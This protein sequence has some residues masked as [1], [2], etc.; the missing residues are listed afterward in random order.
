MAAR[1]RQDIAADPTRGVP[2]KGVALQA[3]VGL[4]SALLACD[5]RSMSLLDFVV[6][7]VHRWPC[8]NHAA[9]ATDLPLTTPPACSTLP[10]PRLTRAVPFAAAQ[11]ACFC[12]C[13]LFKPVFGVGLNHLPMGGFTPH[14]I[15][16]N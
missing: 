8:R 16:I 10:P 14:A 5:F 6:V 13:D 3:P 9:G 7:L 2:K 4:F 11:L 12:A 15:G 1:R